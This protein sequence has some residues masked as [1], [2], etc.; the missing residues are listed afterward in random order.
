MRSV[1]TVITIEQIEGF[2][3][4]ILYDVCI[5]MLILRSTSNNN[6]FQIQLCL[7]KCVFKYMYDNY[8]IKYRLL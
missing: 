7:Y 2:N 1:D 3:V 4:L 5:L 8:T 6:P